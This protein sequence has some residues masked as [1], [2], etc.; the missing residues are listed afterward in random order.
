[1]AHPNSLRLNEDGREPFGQTIELELG[2]LEEN[3]SAGR[4]GTIIKAFFQ[5]QPPAGAK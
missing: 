5:S 4:R 3:E 1:M 2:V